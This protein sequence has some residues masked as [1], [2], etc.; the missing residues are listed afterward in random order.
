MVRAIAFPTWSVRARI[1]AVILVITTVGMTFAGISAYFVQRDRVIESIDQ[2]LLAAVESARQVLANP[3]AAAAIDEP[4]AEEPAAGEAPTDPPA[5]PEAPAAPAYE[6]VGEALEAILSYVI[7]GRHESSIALLDGA[8]A[9]QP[10]VT[11]SFELADDPAL[12]AR[13]WEESQGGT[14]VLGTAN[15]SALEGVRAV[16]YVVAP[17]EIAGSDQRGAYV[18]AIDVQREVDEVGGAFVT[19]AWLSALTILL[20]GAAGWFV[21]GRL[22]A[23]L[24]EL[25]LAA[26]RITAQ[27][28]TERIPVR[29]RDDLGA[30]TTTVNDMLDRIDGAF[31][32]Q[33]QL[34]DDV[35]H[36]LKTPI[37]IVRGHLELLDP[38]KPSEVRAVRDIAIDE[39]D[40][41]S[42]LVSDIDDLARTERGLLATEPTDVADLTAAVFGK[43]QAIGDHEWVLES[44]VPV[45][46][47]VSP[48]RITQAW[49]Q[50]ADNAAKYSPAGSTIRIGSSAYRGAVE[51]WVADE[52]P[53]IPEE[54]RTRIFERFGRADTG[55][56]V[57]GSGLGLP[58]VAAIARAHGGHVS[59]E[60]SEA[61]SRFGIVVPV[62]SDAPAPPPPADLGPAARDDE[63]SR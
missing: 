1:L 48:S 62:E 43:A 25:R 4:P 6:T 63:E 28:T 42:E 61:G 22:L 24:R 9:W 55:R 3:P 10:S 21:S 50:L 58:I 56:G 19:Y 18:T 32:A 41:M 59:L 44:S 26:E 12:L 7:P 17:V 29:T 27:N 34:L 37:T 16:R 54:S 20:I 14:V 40:R 33:R 39:L 51:F 11:V 15:T 8:P 53:G 13:A 38:R 31:T 47:P 46:A 49:L 57:A 23:P 52:G 5:E 30:L 60:T 45:V 2:E 36:E 35:R